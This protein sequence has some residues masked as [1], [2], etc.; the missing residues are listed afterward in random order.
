[1]AL[2]ATYGVN[3]RAGV[4]GVM[5]EVVFPLSA[6]RISGCPW[7]R[8]L[9]AE[10]AERSRGATIELLIAY[11]RLG[12]RAGTLCETRKFEFLLTSEKIGGVVSSL[13]GLKRN[14]ADV[15]H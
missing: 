2:A 5:N 11:P 3:T 8:L 6:C 13:R 1:M 12:G 9:A 10:P 7:Q 4:R 14:A 15:F